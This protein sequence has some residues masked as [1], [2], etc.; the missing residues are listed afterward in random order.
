MHE[1]NAFHELTKVVLAIK[2][3]THLTRNRFRGVVHICSMCGRFSVLGCMFLHI[4]H[5]NVLLVP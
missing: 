1:T 2:Y 4:F 3:L 5:D